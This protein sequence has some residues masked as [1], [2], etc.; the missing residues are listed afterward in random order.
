MLLSN[1]IPRGYYLLPRL[2][3]ETK[4]PTTPRP[5]SLPAHYA[6]QHCRLNPPLL[7]GTQSVS[8]DEDNNWKAYSSSWWVLIPL[9]LPIPTSTPQCSSTL[10]TTRCCGVLTLVRK[11][12]RTVYLDTYTLFLCSFFLLFCKPFRHAFFLLAGFHSTASSSCIVVL[13]LV[14][15]IGHFQIVP[16]LWRCVLSALGTW[17][18]IHYEGSVW[19]SRLPSSW[20][21]VVR[22]EMFIIVNAP[23]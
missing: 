17:N 7:L 15:K 10:D 16:H 8:C 21:V 6:F 9:L 19:G 5:F 22:T 18:C 4:A 23:P 2:L 20:I 13:L 11:W 1:Y 3:S 12:R 14:V